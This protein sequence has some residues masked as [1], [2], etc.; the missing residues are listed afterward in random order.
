MSLVL[1]ILF[2]T[3]LENEAKGPWVGGLEGWGRI[4]LAN[5]CAE[6]ICSMPSS[7]QG[8]VRLS[9]VVVDKGRIETGKS[10]QGQTTKGLV[11]RR[12]SLDL[13]LAK[14]SFHRNAAGCW[15]GL[16]EGWRG[17]NDARDTAIHQSGE[18]VDVRE[19]NPCGMFITSGPTSL[20]YFRPSYLAHD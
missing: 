14:F 8:L 6:R 20:S 9:N 3:V 15:Y 5:F 1:V 17:L 13:L 12:R 4:V 18:A 10:K 16:V 2:P 7:V 19:H 11:F